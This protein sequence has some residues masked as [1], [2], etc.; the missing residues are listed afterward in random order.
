ME[1]VRRP[2]DLHLTPQEVEQR[3]GG[4]EQ[5]ATTAALLAKRVKEGKYESLNDLKQ[6]VLPMLNQGR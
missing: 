6:V 1:S 4:I 3:A 5:I 2:H